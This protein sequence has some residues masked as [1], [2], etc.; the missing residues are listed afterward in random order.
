MRKFIMLQFPGNSFGLVVFL[1]SKRAAVHF[2]QSDD[3]RIH[4]FYEIQ[5]FFQIT[6]GMLEVAAI[7]HRKVKVFPNPGSI[8]YIIQKKSHPFIIRRS[9]YSYNND[10]L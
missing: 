1:A 3:I 9:K 8:A 4:R 6:V 10:L 5:D 7:R 2:D